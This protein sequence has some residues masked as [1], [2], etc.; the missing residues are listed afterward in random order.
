MAERGRFGTLRWGIINHLIRGQFHLRDREHPEHSRARL[1]ALC[2]LCICLI[3]FAGFA[4]ANHVHKSSSTSADHECSVC[5]VAH[6]GALINAAY[7][8]VPVFIRS[9]F[10]LRDEVSAKPLLLGCFLYIR[11]PPSA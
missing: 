1:T 9:H 3:L 5:S 10:T 11:P 4:Q 2:L 6:A 8:L 7:R